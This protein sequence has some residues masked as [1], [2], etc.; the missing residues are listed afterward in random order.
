MN[1]LVE[2]F[3]SGLNG[4][5]PPLTEEY[6][7]TKSLSTINHQTLPAFSQ[8][9]G[10]RSSFRNYSPPYPSQQTAPLTGNVANDTVPWSY[11]TSSILYS[12]PPAQRIQSNGPTQHRMSAAA[13]LTASKYLKICDFFFRFYFII[14]CLQSFLTIIDDDLCNKNLRVLNVYERIIFH[15][16]RHDIE[17]GSMFVEEIYIV[18]RTKRLSNHGFVTLAYCSITRLES[19]GIVTSACLVLDVRSTR[20][21]GFTLLFSLEGHFHIHV[22]VLSYLLS[23]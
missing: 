7:S 21:G 1:G 23:K 12:S 15:V 6:D 8:P 2:L 22:F 19:F 20:F 17:W 3:L 10:S 18:S 14:W 13:S 4:T 9:F 5:L 16:E 11:N